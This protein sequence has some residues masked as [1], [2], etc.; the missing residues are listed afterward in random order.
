MY[1]VPTIIWNLPLK[2]EPASGGV[3]CNCN[4]LACR[5]GNSLIRSDRSDQMTQ[6]ATVSDSL[7]SLR[8]NEQLW[9]NRSGRSCQKS[10]CEQIAQVAHQKWAMWANRSSC[11]PKMSDHV[12]I[13]QIAHFFANNERFAQ[14]TN[15]RIPN[16]AG[17]LH[18]FLAHKTEKSCCKHSFRDRWVWVISRQCCR[19][20]A[21]SEPVN[22]DGSGSV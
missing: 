7:R 17:L 18:K 5:V 8:T 19:V 2:T 15:E 22:E 3:K 14:K 20:G 21:K 10:D 9:A 16:P 1:I 6:W 11:S 12:R 4:C 13:A